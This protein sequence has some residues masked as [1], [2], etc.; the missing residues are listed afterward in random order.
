MY[1]G[2]FAFLVWK[3]VSAAAAKSVEGVTDVDQRVRDSNPMSD[4][5]ER[6]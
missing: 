1:R 6:L 4:D 2:A 3:M 5:D